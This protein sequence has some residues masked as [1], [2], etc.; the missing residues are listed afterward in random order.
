MK[1][2]R[3]LSNWNRKAYLKGDGSSSQ[4]AIQSLPVQNGV[5]NAMW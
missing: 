5:L 1:I 4:T 3:S 2:D